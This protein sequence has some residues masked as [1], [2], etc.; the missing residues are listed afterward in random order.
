M[1]T[2][3]PTAEQRKGGTE[4]LK[5]KVSSMIHSNQE[6]MKQR[7]G[8]AE[9]KKEKGSENLSDRDKILRESKDVAELKKAVNEFRAE[10]KEEK[11]SY[12]GQRY[13]QRVEAAADTAMLQ[14]EKPNM[15]SDEAFADV[16]EQFEDR[17]TIKTLQRPRTQEGVLETEKMALETGDGPTGGGGDVL[18][19]QDVKKSDVV[20]LEREDPT[21][22][23]SAFEQEDDSLSI[24]EAA[25]RAIKK[26]QDE[27]FFRTRSQWQGQGGY[28]FTYVPPETPEGEPKIIVEAP[29]GR[30]GSSMKEG[31][32]AVVTPD[33]RND[34]GQS[35]FAAIIGERLGG[36]E[37][38]EYK[39]APAPARRGTDTDTEV[40]TQDDEPATEPTGLAD[41][42][43]VPMV[44]SEDTVDYITPPAAPAPALVFTD[45]AEDQ[46][47]EPT[48][49]ADDQAPAADDAVSEMDTGVV[50]ESSMDEPASSGAELAGESDT[51]DV[52]TQESPL[53]EGLDFQSVEDVKA[54]RD[55]R[56]AEEEERKRREYAELQAKREAEAERIIAENERIKRERRVEAI[57]RNVLNAKAALDDIRNRNVPDVV[58]KRFVDRYNAALQQYKDEVQGVADAQ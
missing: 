6:K 49:L 34:K 58:I 32:R 20:G 15:F 31:T 30:K 28:N 56:K 26:E 38:K 54:E 42:V 57:K 7:L 1:A 12:P 51:I 46:A 13:R 19:M 48:D 55:L 44:A 40:D 41:D 21:Y 24:E 4:D 27:D 23:P 45:S 8:K 5:G 52:S 53:L 37:V 17:E 9:D 2:E 39:A 11:E 25:A 18:A 33:S 36:G 16:P 35:L 47:P 14:K 10:Q 29:V 3:E 43:P 22:D 50:Q